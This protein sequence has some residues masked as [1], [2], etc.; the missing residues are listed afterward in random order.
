MDQVSTQMGKLGNHTG[1]IIVSESF[2]ETACTF[3][4]TKRNTR[5]S[6]NWEKDMAKENGGKITPPKTLSIT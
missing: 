6:F 1:V 5:D 4:L 2:M 3:Y